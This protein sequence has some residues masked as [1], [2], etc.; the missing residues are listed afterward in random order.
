MGVIACHPQKNLQLLPLITAC[1][2]FPL[3]SFVIPAGTVTSVVTPLVGIIIYALAKPVLSLSAVP[4]LSA[5][6]AP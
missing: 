2:S 6:L 5:I 3:L 4:E 1:G